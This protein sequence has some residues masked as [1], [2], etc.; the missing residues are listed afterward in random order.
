MSLEGILFPDYLLLY[1]LHFHSSATECPIGYTGQLIW[2]VSADTV[3]F[4][5]V[6][7]TFTSTLIYT[8]EDRILLY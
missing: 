3:H 8:K 1:C 5:V 6:Q 2:N 7:H 4:I